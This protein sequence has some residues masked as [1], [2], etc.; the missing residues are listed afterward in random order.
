[1]KY[2]PEARICIVGAGPAGLTAA[3]MLRDK[4]YKHITILERAHR[5]GGKCYS[6]KRGGRSYELGA[7]IVA[8]SS[9]LIRNLA[10]KYHVPMERVEFAN[11]MYL[12]IKTGKPLQRSFA[13]RAKLLWQVVLYWRL[14]RKYRRIAEPGFANIDKDLCEPFNTW[15]EKNGI[16]LLAQEFANYYTGF[17]YGFQDKVA[18][19]YVLKY[20]PWDIVF[21]Y[22]K[23]SF[24]KFP[25]GIQAL[26]TAVAKAHD[27]EYGIEIQRI[28]RG[29]TI[30]VYTN[31]GEK[32]FDAIILTSP[33]DESLSFL[34]GSEQEKALFPKIE[35]EDYRT[36]ACHVTHFPKVT[37][38]VPGNLL[39]SRVGEPVF[40]Y[41]RYLDSDLYTFYVFGNRSL[42]NDDVLKN[43]ERV[44]K[45]LGG[46]LGET[47]NIEYW[48]FFPHLSPEN[49]RAGF[50]DELESL[51]G[52]NNTFY[53]GEVMNF[54][55]VT[56]S[57]AYA[58]N[59]VER[60][61]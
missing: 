30:V 25:D 33:L 22:L 11:R 59:V 60:F 50:F 3:E 21:A 49:L 18:A 19:A 55:T 42:S 46:T 26:W 27:V 36:Y 9:K 47:E 54:S 17:G 48:K 2:G 31:V 29:D 37:G 8:D 5:A 45:Q 44:V 43:I 51:Q 34:D 12:D 13:E 57:A 40:W 6:I 56:H 1:M 38:Y 15:A 16:P 39:S 10:E 32:I 41:Q 28:K 20:Y 23:R 52:R 61:F 4:G 14:A 24:Y 35:Y 7:G 53:A 58:K